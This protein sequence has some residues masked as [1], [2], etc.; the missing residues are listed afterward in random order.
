MMAPAYKQAATQLEPG[1][2]LLQVDPEAAQ[3]LG[4]RYNIRS[5]PAVKLFVD[6]EV[7]GEF[8]GALPEPQVRSW[9]QGVMPSEAKELIAKAHEYLREGDK[10]A[11]QEC[12]ERAL[13]LEPKFVVLDEPTSALDVSIQA[14]VVDLLRDIQQSHGLTYMF[15]S[16]DL[17]VV[18]AL[19]NQLIVMRNGKIVEHGPANDIFL[20]P[21]SDYTKALMAAAF[22]VAEIGTT[23]LDSPVAP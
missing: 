1:V 19:A 4:A 18:R 12:L 22:D 14:Q 17:K 3:E 15:I 7:A 8:L 23:S 20:A 21:R 10:P 16:H 13:V 5:I 6:G 9:L 11:A 2:R